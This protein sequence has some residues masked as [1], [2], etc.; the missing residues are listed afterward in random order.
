[1]TVCAGFKSTFGVVLGADSQETIGTM[2]FGAPKLVIMPSVG[3]P[4]DKVRMM[5]AGAGNGAFI[6]KLIEKMW[7]AALRGP[8]MSMQK[9]F[10][11]VEDANIE[12]HRKIWE[13]CVGGNRPEAEILVAIYTDRCVNLYRVEGPIISPVDHY[14]FVGIG[15]ELGTFLA[16]HLNSD[17]SGIEEDIG[18]AIY[19]LENVKTYVDACGGDTQLAALMLDGSIQ[20]MNSRD[21]DTLAKAMISMSRNIYYLFSL[22]RDLNTRKV[23]IDRSARATA[24]EIHRIRAE[25]RKQLRRTIRVSPRLKSAV[26]VYYRKISWPPTRDSKIEGE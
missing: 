13:A 15:G 4:E 17:S 14:A 6:D 2:K 3:A 11:R 8:E 26:D 12:W 23:D 19:I 10:D 20:Q 5:F 25:L 16:E 7:E 18:D 1:V 22:A 9:V 24:R 21:S